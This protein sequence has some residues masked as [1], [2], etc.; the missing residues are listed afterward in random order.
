[1]IVE[2]AGGEKTTTDAEG[3]REIRKERRRKIGCLM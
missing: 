3:G 1:M 2:T